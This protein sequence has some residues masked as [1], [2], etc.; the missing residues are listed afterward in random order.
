MASMSR[1]RKLRFVTVLP[2]KLEE[3]FNFFADAENLG[4]ITPPWLHFTICSPRPI[5]MDVGTLIDYRIRLR[6]VPM[7]WRTRI[8]AWEPCQRFID[9]QMNGPYSLWRHEHVFEEVTDSSGRVHVR[10]TDDVEYAL[11][12]GLLGELAQRLF[13]GRDLERIF[14]FRTRRIQE[15]F[16]VR[17]A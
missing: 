3:V 14:M 5:E 6:G 8:A 11:P 15:I 17:D 1:V 16:A 13:V 4:E 7:K 10:M 2:G 12:M 9:E